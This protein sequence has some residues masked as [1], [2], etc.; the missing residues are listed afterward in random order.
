MAI[1][2]EPGR[3]GTTGGGGPRGGA[4]V[5][6]W[7]ARPGLHTAIVGAVVGYAFGHWLGNLSTSGYP[8]A[9]VGGGSPDSN[10]TPIVLGYLFL[11]IGWLAAMG[12][13][14]DLVRL[15]TGKRL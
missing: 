7:W 13:F 3:T 14:N 8:Q 9:S 11:V 15:M 6:P 5:R 1:E 10:D 2:T 4:R 12:V